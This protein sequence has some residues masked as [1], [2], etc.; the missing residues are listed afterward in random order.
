MTLKTKKIFL[1]IIFIISIFYIGFA[2]FLMQESLGIFK[3]LRSFVSMLLFAT[4][5]LGGIVWRTSSED[6]KKVNRIS[7]NM[8]IYG[9][10]GLIV[11]FS[12]YI[13]LSFRA[14]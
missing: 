4:L 8:F 11:V 3:G 10:I 1:T 9:L 13:I 12:G 14:V 7:K 2:L 6:A 5:I